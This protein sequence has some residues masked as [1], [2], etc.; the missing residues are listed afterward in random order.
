MV[1]LALGCKDEGIK[2][3]K[4]ENPKVNTTA[5]T[6]ADEKKTAKNPLV[7]VSNNK[8]N[9][10]ANTATMGAIHIHGYKL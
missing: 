5:T 7:L 4:T 2:N 9:K 10:V 6:L 1:K 8:A 3:G